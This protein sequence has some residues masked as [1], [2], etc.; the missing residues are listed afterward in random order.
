[1]FSSTSLISAVLLALSVAAGPVVLI[2][3]PSLTLPIIRRFNITGTTIADADR[4][5]AIHLKENGKKLKSHSQR[6][7]R[8]SSF[9]VT[10]TAVTY[11][12][13]VG[14]GSPAT[15]YSLLIDTGSSNTW[16]GADKAYVQTSTSENTGNNVSV[17]YGSGSFSGA[18]YTDTV[19]LSSDLVIMGQRIGVASTSSGFEGVDGI[20]GLGPVDLTEGTVSGGGTVLTVTDNLFSQGTITEEVVGVYYAPTTVESTTNGELTFGGVDTSKTTSDISYVST[21]STSPASAYWGVDQS[22]TYGSSGTEVL[23]STAGIVDT[24]TTLVLLATDA[25]NTY[26][27]LTGATLDDS[28]GLLSIS[29]SDYENLQSLFFNIGDQTYELT[30]N[31]QTWP[32]SLNAAIGGS[33]NTIYLVVSDLG[34]N[35]G[36]G[37]DFINGYTFLERFYSVY[38][39]TNSR[40]GFATTEHT[41]DTSN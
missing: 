5:R 26:V 41:S 32:R 34:S 21:T 30:A 9:D 7:R 14:V 3:E 38:D 17:T 23:S 22:I 40:V 24:G 27:S 15:T 18:E 31:A 19:T 8:Q 29:R 39:T 13:D 25:Y 2:R 4:A 16:V 1:M 33:S 37:L 10:N 11:T 6:Y 35:S 36:E 20:L 28:V 12:A